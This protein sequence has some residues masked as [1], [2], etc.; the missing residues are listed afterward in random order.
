MADYDLQYQDTYID[1]LLATANELKTAGYIYK[2]VATPSTNPGTPT[3]RVAYLAS[4]PGTYTNFGGIVIASGLYSLTYASGTW[5]GTQMSAGSD[6]EVVQTTGDST[7][8]VMSQKAVTDKICYKI[9][10]VSHIEQ[11]NGYINGQH[12]KTSTS[13]Y[14]GWVSIQAYKG[15]KIKITAGSIRTTGVCFFQ[16][17]VR[18]NNR[19]L[20]NDYAT[21]WSSQVGVQPS[22]SAYFVV[23]DDAQYLYVL[24]KGTDSQDATPS[25]VELIY[26]NAPNNADY[27]RAP[28]NIELTSDDFEQGAINVFGVE[29]DNETRIKSRYIYVGGNYTECNIT[30]S[31]FK[32]AVYLYDKDK[33]Y[34]GCLYWWQTYKFM[35]AYYIRVIVGYTNDSVISMADIPLITITSG[36]SVLEPKED[37]VESDVDFLKYENYN[38][39]GGTLNFTADDFET[40]GIATSGINDGVSNTRARSKH[41]IDVYD[42]DADVYLNNTSYSMY[43]F[44]YDESK[45]LLTTSGAWVNNYKATGGRYVRIAIRKGNGSASFSPADINWTDCYIKLYP[46][47]SIAISS[48]IIY[49]YME[50]FKS[51]PSTEI[52]EEFQSFCKVGNEFW[53]ASGGSGDDAGSTIDGYIYR[54][55]SEW[56]YIGRMRQTVAHW[57]SMSYDP[58]TDRLITGQMGS[59]SNKIY[60]FGNVSQWSTTHAST[61]IT[62]SDIERTI[63]ISQVSNR[64]NPVWAERNALGHRDI[65]ISG[66][67]NS[68]FLK[69]RLG[70]GTNQLSN[71]TYTASSDGVPNGTYD[72]LWNIP[73]TPP[74]EIYAIAAKIPQYPTAVCQGIDYYKGRIYSMSTVT[75][76][77]ILELTPNGNMM[78]Y[79]II[80]QLWSDDSGNAMSN[81]ANEGIM[82]LDGKVY[83]GVS[84]IGTTTTITEYNNKI[85]RFD[86]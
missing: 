44:V 49:P 73:F 56:S 72:V 19:V 9:E 63:I 65:I 80:H 52:N 16:R 33:N 37:V 34:I 32:Y 23:P 4:E 74:A 12:W 20:T 3:E 85:L 61:A 82:C 14:G 55:N 11:A 60:V 1:A 57:N 43:V 18:T 50:V 62:S 25:S 79:R 13:Y 64:P 53:I 84:A 27:L 22:A 76:S 68:V 81:C 70:Y 31:N 36:A 2:G 58:A 77:T 7:T 78:D 38:H 46:T 45:T 24:L 39:N 10:L 42:C 15:K 71:G 48:G 26:D 75:P 83:V 41:Y 54:Y 21:G 67:L 86:L 8:D 29:A 30:G 35:D 17:K 69:I 59:T 66:N 47:G 40:G 6:I 51:I 5:T 28:I